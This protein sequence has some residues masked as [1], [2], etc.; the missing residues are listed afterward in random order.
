M[1]SDS[2][3]VDAAIGIGALLLV[4]FLSCIG[5]TFWLYNLFTSVPELPEKLKVN[6]VFL[7]E[8]IKIIDSKHVKQDKLDIYFYENFPLAE[9]KDKGSTDYRVKTSLHY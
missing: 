4:L 3:I 9:F 6:E 1:S 7:L 2:N 8:N 5:I